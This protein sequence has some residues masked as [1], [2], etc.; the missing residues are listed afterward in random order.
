MNKSFVFLMVFSLSISAQNLQP[1]SASIVLESY[2][3]GNNSV[4]PIGILIE[5]EKDWYIYWFN[6]GDSGMPTTID[7]DLPEGIIISDLKWPAPDIFEFEGL[8][9]YGFKDKVLLLADL[10]IPDNFN[11]DTFTITVNLNS[12][13]CK[14]VCIPFN[15]SISK[16]VSLAN[17][18]IADEQ[19]KKIFEQTKNTLPRT[20]H[21]LVLSV[22]SED[23]FIKIVIDK[24]EISCSETKSVYFLPYENGLFKNT[25]GQKLS[26][27]GSQAELFVEYDHFKTKDL[28]EAH[29]LLVFE[30]EKDKLFKKIYEIKKPL[31]K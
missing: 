1:A 30:F 28:A 26:M 14:H 27:K 4:I 21:D 17:D 24:G 11:T 2:S 22:F 13:I 16:E 31:I 8:A 19:T 23:E 10:Y 12:L 18:N 9:S 3:A 7:F 25:I 29:G 5:L 6:P 15:A 20:K